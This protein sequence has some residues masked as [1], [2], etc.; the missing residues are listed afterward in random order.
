MTNNSILYTKPGC[1]LCEEARAVIEV[2]AL[3][4]VVNEVDISENPELM[5]RYGLRI[6]VLVVAG[7]KRELE[8]PFGPA[9]LQALLA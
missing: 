2:A 7:R 1:H 8:W 4:L 6:P 5:A 3:G 9:E